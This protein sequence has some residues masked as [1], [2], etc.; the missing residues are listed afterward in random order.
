MRTIQTVSDLY[1]ALG[2]D[3]IRKTGGHGHQVMSRALTENTLPSHWLPQIRTMCESA[4]YD[5]PEHLFRFNKVANRR[6]GERA[7]A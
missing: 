5:V 3:A 6:A 2:R 4:G 7:S 1:D